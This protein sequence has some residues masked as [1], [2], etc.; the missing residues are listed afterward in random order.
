MDIKD[1]IKLS[2]E[3][4]ASVNAEA[5]VDKDMISALSKASNLLIETFLNKGK[6][7]LAGNGGSAADCQH[8]AA[9]FIGRL[10]FDRDPLPAI[11][12]TSN[13]SN[14]TCIA[15]D[16]GYEEIF[17]RQMH[18]LANENDSLIVYSTSGKSKN[19]IK[20]VAEAKNKV[21]NIIALTGNY[22]EELSKHADVVISVKA[23]KT[24]RIQEIHAIAGHIM[25]ECVEETLFNT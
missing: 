25:C 1:I 21:K 23:S 5:S 24:T 16:Y 3:E 17:T 11:A 9:E 15:N 4:S 6:I 2:L 13:T 14:L 8:I 19:I 22:T 7:L 10:N 18:A 20:L 12:L